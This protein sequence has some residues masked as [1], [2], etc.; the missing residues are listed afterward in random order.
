VP[1]VTD[2]FGRPVAGQFY[3]VVQAIVI[4][5]VDPD[6]L[7]RVKVKMMDQPDTPEAFWARLIMP[8]AGR[9]RG[10]MTIPEV[11]D[12]VLIAFLW[13]DF[14]HAIVMGSLY[15]GVDTPPYANE[16]EEDNLRVFQSRS[17][18]RF[19]FD[20]TE[21]AERCELILHNEEIRVIWNSAEKVMSVYAGKDIKMTVLETLSMKTKDFIV[22]ASNSIALNAGASFHCKGTTESSV[23][24]DQ[25]LTIMA[26]T[27]NLN[28]GGGAQAQ[29][30]PL[31]DYKHPPRK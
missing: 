4:D 7:G 31:P 20:D 13:G 11:D 5:N 27:I 10:W 2:R 6:E 24:G 28:M 25:Q 16:D 14:A 9:E 15:N 1:K 22:D 26:A 3:G 17:G 8:M 23:V 12:E 29:A 21:G 19:T 30:L 18:H